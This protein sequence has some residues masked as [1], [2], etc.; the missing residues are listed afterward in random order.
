MWCLVETLIFWASCQEKYLDIYHSNQSIKEGEGFS[1]NN[2][3]F[4]NTTPFH[5]DEF[6][7]QAPRKSVLYITYICSSAFKKELLVKKKVW[8]CME[9]ND[10]RMK[11]LSKLFVRMC[12]HATINSSTITFHM[13]VLP[14]QAIYLSYNFWMDL[15]R[16]SRQ[17]YYN[18]YGTR[19]RTLKRYCRREWGSTPNRFMITVYLIWEPWICTSVTSI[20]RESV[21]DMMEHVGFGLVFPEIIIEMKCASYILLEYWCAIDG[22]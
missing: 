17:T 10:M 8:W 5:N 2:A 20:K 13:V 11:H 19:Y 3:N 7:Q 14:F 22:R 21:H 18:C 9:R 16:I 4:S 12:V 1:V 15:G 6:S